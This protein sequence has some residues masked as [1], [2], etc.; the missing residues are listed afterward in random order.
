MGYN[1]RNLKFLWLMKFVFNDI[2]ETI[3]AFNV[4]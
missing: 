4:I 1:W 2:N 3:E